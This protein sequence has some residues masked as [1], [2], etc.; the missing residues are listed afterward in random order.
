MYTHRHLTANIY[1][2]YYYYY[3]EQQIRQCITALCQV[4]VQCALT[5][6]SRILSI[7]VITKWCCNHGIFHGSRWHGESVTPQVDHVHITIVLSCLCITMV[8]SC[9]CE[10]L[11]PGTS[12]GAQSLKRGRLSSQKSPS[13]KASPE[14]VNV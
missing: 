5:V 3:T 6:D 13:S 9:A 10:V 1:D 8:T 4:P 14:P 12:L 7:H 2:H 11:P